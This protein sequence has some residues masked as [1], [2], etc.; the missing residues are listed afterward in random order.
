MDSAWTFTSAP[1]SDRDPNRPPLLNLRITGG[2]DPLNQA[3]A[4]KPFTLTMAVET[5]DSAPLP[6]TVATL[7]VSY[8]AGATWQPLELAAKGTEWTATVRH[9]DRPGFVAL[10][11]TAQ[12]RAGNRVEQTVH[13]AYGLK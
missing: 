4:G 10:R 13:R 12:D 1:G 5:M 11:A 9:P 3:P 2:F 8:D 7:Q 6:A